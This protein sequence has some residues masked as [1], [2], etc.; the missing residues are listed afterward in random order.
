MARPLN[1]RPAIDRI[2]DRSVRQDDGCIVWTGA[3]QGRYGQI[4]DNGKTKYV[5]R[6]VYEHH[7][8]EIPEEMTIDHECCN[9]LCV[10]ETHLAVATREENGR[11]GGLERFLQRT[12]S[13]AAG[14]MSI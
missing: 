1:V 7:F 11:L 9:K 10:N 3:T 4:R 2:R 5:H 14:M 13:Q 8:G 12:L 6:V